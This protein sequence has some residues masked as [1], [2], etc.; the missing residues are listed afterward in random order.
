M[1]HFSRTELIDYRRLKRR[2][3]TNVLI[4]MRWRRRTAEVDIALNALLGRGEGDAADV[5]NRRALS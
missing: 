3:Q 5:L 1:R 4:A 2:G